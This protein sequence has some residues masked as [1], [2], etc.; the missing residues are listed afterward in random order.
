MVHW[1]KYTT[2]FVL[3]LL[4]YMAFTHTNWWCWSALVYAWLLIP[5]VE[6]L[7]QPNT[8][9]LSETEEIAAKKDRMYDVVLYVAV[10]IHIVLM[11]V[12]L[13]SLQT[14]G[15][16]VAVR[17]ARIATMGLLCGTFGIN[18]AHELGHRINQ[19]KQAM[20]KIALLTSLYMHFFLEHNRGHISGW[21]R[22][23]T[24]G[25]ASLQVSVYRF[26]IRSVIGTYVNAWRIANKYMQQ[27][28]LPVIHYQN[29]M[30][31][32]QVIQLIW[33]MGIW[34]FMG[35]KIALYY[36]VTAIIVFFIIRNRELY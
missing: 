8:A 27:Q 19:Y 4:A 20:A 25:T 11:F 9:N 29:E 15:L 33:V 14:T 17:I 5:F 28:G 18:V 30:L 21:Q 10:I 36:I 32:M 22:L 34:F 35:W 7:Q 13:H 31:Q 2:S 1:L 12:F 24:P 6:L 3:F 23:K 16:P 26:W